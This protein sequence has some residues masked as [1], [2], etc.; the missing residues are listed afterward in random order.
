MKTMIAT[1]ITMWI[2]PPTW[3][4][5]KPSSQRTTEDGGNDREHVLT[6]W[7]SGPTP[8]QGRNGLVL[9]RFRR[10]VRHPCAT[11]GSG[12][13]AGTRIRACAFAIRAFAAAYPFSV[14]LRPGVP[15]PRDPSARQ[16]PLYAG[17][18]TEKGREPFPRPFRSRRTLGTQSGPR[19]LSRIDLDPWT[20]GAQDRPQAGRSGRGAGRPVRRT[21][22]GV[23]AALPHLL[24][25]KGSAL[26]PTPARPRRP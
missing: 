24:H 23:P 19:G 15:L 7:L 10:S 16:R 6:P 22:P 8:C 4:A 9:T 14:P 1:T 26:T 12:L 2:T 11:G 5:R 13:S 18:T 21:G 20:L 25:A 17:M 3:K